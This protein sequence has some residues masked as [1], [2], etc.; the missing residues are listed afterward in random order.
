[1]KIFELPGI[2]LI[3][4]SG[5]RAF[6][7]NYKKAYFELK[8]KPK[9]KIPELLQRRHA[10]ASLPMCTWTFLLIRI[11]FRRSCGKHG[12]KISLLLLRARRA[13][14]TSLWFRRRMVAMLF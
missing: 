13:G 3:I 2:A 7:A 4:R 14:L 9:E 1:M 6:G 12:V 10:S 8:S 11:R 5:K